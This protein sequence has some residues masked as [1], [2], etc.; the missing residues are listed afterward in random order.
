MIF[1]KHKSFWK[2]LLEFEVQYRLRERV[3]MRSCDLAEINSWLLRRV[4]TWLIPSPAASTRMIQAYN[5][6]AAGGRFVA[7]VLVV[8]DEGFKLYRSVNLFVIGLL[9]REKFHLWGNDF[10][11]ACRCRRSWLISIDSMNK[12]ILAYYSWSGSFTPSREAYLEVVNVV[13]SVWYILVRCNCKLN[14]M[15]GSSQRIAPTII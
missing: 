8:T 13:G 9:D 7:R 11:A 14:F 3:L 5:S 12:Q 1:W 15:M 4:L 10:C 6:Q 2:K